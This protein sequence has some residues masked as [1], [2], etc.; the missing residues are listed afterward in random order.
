VSTLGP[1][2]T[3]APEFFSHPSR[4]R[5]APAQNEEEA[6]QTDQMKVV[7]VARL[8][9]HKDIGEAE[10]KQCGGDST[11]QAQGHADCE[12]TQ[13]RQ[14]A[15]TFQCQTGAIF[16]I[17]VRNQGGGPTEGDVKVE[18]DLPPE[19]TATAAQGAG[20]NCNISDRPL[21]CSRSLIALI[22][23][24]CLMASV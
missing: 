10:E 9:Q 5:D 17:A 7:Q 23:D 12:R 19:L 18:D 15:R 8:L 4:W 3:G 20:W 21:V 1:R 6:D 22:Q 2:S 14:S 13:R 16:I 24:S 11:E